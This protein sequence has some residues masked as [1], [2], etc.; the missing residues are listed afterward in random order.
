MDR[1]GNVIS[2]EARTNSPT[3]FEVDHKF[4]RSRGGT[5]DFRNLDAVFWYA[6]SYRKG[7]CIIAANDGNN[8]FERMRCGVEPSDVK[9]LLELFPN[10]EFRWAV[11]LLE[12]PALV[13][14]KTWNP[15]K[16]SF[17]Q[18]LLSKAVNVAGDLLTDLD[19]TQ[20]LPTN[21]PWIEFVGAS[22]VHTAQDLVQKAR[23]RMRLA[24]AR[25][26]ALLG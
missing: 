13:S 17:V 1:Y 3:Y 10:E 20:A 2:R 19:V 4:P 8:F 14:F 24:Q 21:N 5:S 15:K 16:A 26:K 12:Q 6:N 7:D 18:F 25:Y 11:F 23:D 9:T 22:D